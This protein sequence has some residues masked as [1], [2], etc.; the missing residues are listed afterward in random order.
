MSTREP[1][2]P[3]KPDLKQ[4]FWRAA[5]KYGADG[6]GDLAAGLTYFALLSLFPALVALVSLLGVFG[7]GPGTTAALLQV[8]RDLGVSEDSLAPIGD[9]V[10]EQQQTP[11][12]GLALVL[13]LGGALFAA[14]NYVNGFSRAMNTIYGVQEGRPIWKLR[15]WMVLVTLIL[16]VLAM[17]VAGALVLQGPV[18]EAVGSVVGLQDQTAQIWNL[19]KWPAIVVLVVIIVGVLYRLTPNVKQPRFRALTIGAFLAIVVWAVAT[20]GFGIYVSRFGSYNATY[21]ALAGVIVL[22]VWL[23][24]TNSVLLFG[25][26]VDA[27]IERSRQL[28]A[29]VAAE[30]RVQLELRDAAGVAKKEEGQRESVRRMR[31]VRMDAAEGR[32]EE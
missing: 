7:D 9:F 22:L 21:G 31:R 24:L 27:E 20:A 4:A 10:N 14:S 17:L 6:S 30:E 16:V 5:K 23:W 2:A 13:G 25:A 29:G 1:A 3:A 15:P 8:V 11:A 32:L 18:A 26:Q 19:A 12:A 28:Q